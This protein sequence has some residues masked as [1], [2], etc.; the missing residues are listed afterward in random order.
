MGACNQTTRLLLTLAAVFALL[1]G[2]NRAAAQAD[3]S[4]GVISVQELCRIEGQGESVLR[5]VGLV[6]GLKGTGDSGADLVLARPLAEFYKAN[7]NPIPDLRELAKAKSAALVFIEVV[8]PKEGARRDDQLDVYVT[9]SHS[10]MSLAGG[11]LVLAPLL[12]PLAGDDT[13]YAFASGAITLEDPM[14]TTAGVIRGGARLTADVLMP[15][16]G[17]EFN[18]VVHPHYRGWTVTDQ[19]ADTINALAPEV[20]PIAEE[21]STGLI[22]TALDDSTVQVII[23]A[24]ERGNPAKFISRV[25]SATFSPSLLRLPAQVIVNSRTGSIIVTGNVEISTV[26]IA[27]KDLVVSTTTPPPVPSPANPLTE[28]HRSALVQ[29]TGRA[30][31]RARVQDLLQALRQLD[32]PVTDQINILTQIHRAGR[33]HARLIVE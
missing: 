1:A 28:N 31:E 8:I 25:L 14:V 4:A 32:V 11:R 26:A 23:P 24:A 16:V 27:H 22:A 10:A 12:G 9:T 29:T 2:V 30:S 33:L 13:V 18:L 3:A 15:A 21:P 6:T 7:G 19:L 5:G 17:G 20:D